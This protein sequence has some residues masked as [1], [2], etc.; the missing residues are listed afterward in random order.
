MPIWAIMALTLVGCAQAR[1]R[2]VR[3]DLSL[4]CDCHGDPKNGNAAPPPSAWRPP[5]WRD[6][7]QQHLSS[8][9]WHAEIGCEACHLVPDSI[10]S[11]GHIDTGLPAELTWGSL[12]QAGGATPQWDGTRC[13]NYCHGQKLKG[14][15]NTSPSWLVVDGS[16]AACGACHGL[17]P[18]GRHP[19]DTQCSRCHGAVI[20]ESGNIKNPAL[21]INGIVDV[22]GVACNSCHGSAGDSNDPRNWAP[23]ADLSGN[24]STSARGVGAH[25][26]HLQAS[27]WH[28]AIECNACHVVPTTLMDSGH[29]DSPLPA[30]LTFGALA[31]ADGAAPSWDGTT[32]SNY[33]HG[34]TLPPGANTTPS[35]TTVD[36]TQ[37]QCGTSCH[38]LPPGGSHPAND[39]CYLCHG[40]VVDANRT[41]INPSL[42]INGV[43]DAAAGCTVCHASPQGSNGYRRQVAGAG[44]DF[45]RPSHHV[46]NGTSAEI[47]TDDDCQVCHDQVQHMANSDPEVLLNDPDVGPSGA[48][49]YDGTGAS[50]EAFCLDCHDQDGPL[51]YDVDTL[52]ANGR[53]PFTDLARPIDIA[54]GWAGAA[55]ATSPVAELQGEAC[56]ACHGGADST[57][58]GTATGTVAHGSERPHLLSSQVA[59]RSVTNGEE[60]LCFA[61]HDGTL[62]ATDIAAMFAGTE[63][64]TS[65]G[66]ALLNT[67][68]DVSSAAQAYSGAKI[69]CTDCHDPHSANAAA[70]VRAD[71]DP[72]DGTVPTAGARWSGSSSMS[73][74]CLDC[75]DGSMPPTV[76]PPTKA[77]VNIASAY[78][79]DQ[80][81]EGLASTQVVLNGGWARGDVLDCT[82]CHNPG[83]GDDA[84][85]NTYPNLANLRSVI[86]AKD[87]VTP[88]VPQWSW[89]AAV[90]EV[91]RVLDTSAANAD[92]TT[93]GRAFC[94]TCHSN[95]MNGSRT[96]GCLS[97]ACHNHGKNTF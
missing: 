79:S 68:H 92:A 40:A 32:C 36:G 83:H 49:T 71:P 38:S 31:K 62:A 3:D 23:P 29:T 89:D 66:G 85:G 78:T 42:H 27:S 91:V 20:D 95:P 69:E 30:E 52:P 24:T 26:S 1:H 44:G 86:Y 21:H 5:D 10:S 17:P 73:E 18:T 63:T 87:G 80:H 7:H 60:Y 8:S 57:R 19:V 51:A 22:D 90:P 53:Q 65:A 72:N 81:G 58:V 41:I 48:H 11:V 45:E 96:S 54:T 35:W 67:H 47:V 61:C 39:A 55:H 93:N 56:M 2:A 64:M 70:K 12:A 9:G 59:G 15:S 37:A 46:S 76:T 14:G 25:Q 28:A 94:S 34:Q 50:I 16:Q 74:W 13:S 33:C 97:G 43:R 88:L 4:C 82:V 75:H 84:S 6:A 77:L